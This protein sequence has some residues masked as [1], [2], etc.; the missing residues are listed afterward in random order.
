MAFRRARAVSY[1]PAPDGIKVTYWDFGGQRASRMVQTGINV[2]ISRHVDTEVWTTAFK[3]R[4]LTV[5]NGLW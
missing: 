2:V 3:I 4:G 1:M 5:P